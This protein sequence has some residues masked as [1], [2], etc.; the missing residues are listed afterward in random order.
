VKR[1]V[2]EVPAATDTGDLE[3]LIVEPAPDLGARQA[4]H[5]RDGAAI[6]D[7]D[8]A[9]RPGGDAAGSGQEPRS[10]NEVGRAAAGASHPRGVGRPV[11]TVSRPGPERRLADVDLGPNGDAVR[12]LLA[13][14]ANLVDA[15]VRR[16][17]A[18]ASWRWGT[19]TPVLGATSVTAARALAVLRGRGSGRAAGIEAVEA[20]VAALVRARTVRVGRNVGPAIANAGLAQLVRDLV[21]PEVFE[22][23]FGPWR[24]VMHR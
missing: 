2:R 20:T 21:E 17:E 1:K 14:A 22:T 19:V 13:R 12:D 8:G 23:L 9:S 7:S 5:D 4:G 16:L 11:A 10:G 15:D 24:E 6:A 3:E 18:E